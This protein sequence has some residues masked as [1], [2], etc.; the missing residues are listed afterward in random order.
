MT[1]FASWIL[2]DALVLCLA[3]RSLDLWKCRA[4]GRT[5][6]DSRLARQVD[7]VLL[8]G[9]GGV[10]YESLGQ[11]DASARRKSFYE[12]DLRFEIFERSTARRLRRRA[13][14]RSRSSRRSLR[15]TMRSA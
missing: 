13:S 1:I 11:Y 4:C 9:L 12:Y 10:A 14:A 8:G 15:S 6:R 3:E 2:E 5:I 7:N